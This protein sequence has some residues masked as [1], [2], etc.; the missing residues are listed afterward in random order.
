M[1]DLLAQLLD[2][3]LSQDVRPG[4]PHTLQEVSALGRQGRTELAELLAG[5]PNKQS[6]EYRSARRQV[7]RW[8]KKPGTR[9][10]QRSRNR[11]AGAG[12]QA[13]SP[14]LTAF[15]AHGGEMRVKVSW[16]EERKPEWL[17]PQRWIHITQKAMRAVI[18]Y[19]AD[20]DTQLAAG[21]LF[22][23]FAERY[24]VPN[25]DDWLADVVVQDLRLEP[26]R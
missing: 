24:N 3:N 20:G 12:R 5:T 21:L 7:E 23:E 8:A 6:R 15:R 10:E 22:T 9:I 26:T 1:A 25:V 17:P 19:W 2:Q 18:R 16:Y 4:A 13:R 11:L 14:R